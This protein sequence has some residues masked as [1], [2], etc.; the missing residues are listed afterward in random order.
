VGF[1]YRMPNVNAAIGCGQLE[2]LP[3]FLER[4]RTLAQRYAQA[5]A[6]VP[7][8]RVFT[9]PRRSRSNYWLNAVLLDRPDVAARDVVLKALNDAGFQSRPIWRPMHQLPMYRDCPHMDLSVTE[10]LGAR[11]INIPSSAT[12]A[13]IAPMTGE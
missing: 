9:E 6:D 3:G 12:L 13:A 2:Q 5:F 8:V 1:N 11:V 10:D 4:K 7:G